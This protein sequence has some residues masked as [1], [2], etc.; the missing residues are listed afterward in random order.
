[1]K[2]KEKLSASIIF[3]IVMS[4]ACL[5][6]A[7][8]RADQFEGFKK[9][10]TEPALKAFA[11]DLGGLIGGGT[12]HS[13]A[14][15]G[16]PG[17]DLGVHSVVQ[18]RP[19][20]TNSILKDLSDKIVESIVL[21]MAQGEIGLPYNIDVILRGISFEDFAMVGGGLRYG[22]F[23]AKLIPLAPAMAVSVFTH[24]L[25]HDSFSLA[26]YTGNIAFDINVPILS[27]YLGVGWDHTSIKVKQAEIAS[28]I[29]SKIK[30]NGFR[31]TIGLNL[32]PLPLVYV[33]GA[34]TNL[35][36]EEGFEGGFG[37]KF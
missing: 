11:R 26:Q 19:S 7:P 8:V 30:A 36:G 28:L 25:T 35:H 20:A 22:L 31:S 18:K 14:S 24:A 9:F 37:V 27:P 32:K 10:A 2:E 16:F 23:K 15:L 1:M 3:A 12:F 34:Y 4:M 17:V 5:W 6:A 13:G 29:N 21:P 33:H